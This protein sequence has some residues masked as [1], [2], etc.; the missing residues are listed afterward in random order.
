M[1]K[2]NDCNCSRRSFLRGSGLALAGYGLSSLFPGA[3]M[4]HAM[5]MTVATDRRILFI[6][7]RGGN[8]GINT[9]VP[10]GDPDYNDTNRPTLHMNTMETI[11]LGNSFAALHPALS[12]LM[13]PFNAGELAIVHRCG[14]PNNSRSHF[15]GQRIWE[16]GD[17]TQP[18]YFEGWL[19]RYIADSML[20]AGKDLPVITVQRF[21]P[22]IIRGDE[23]FVNI[24]DPDNFDYIYANQNKNDKVAAYWRQQYQDLDGL[25]AYRPL[26]SQTGVKLVD[27]IDEYASWDAANWDPLDPDPPNYSLFPGPTASNNPPQFANQQAFDFFE[28]VKICALALLESDGSPNNGTRISGTEIGGWDTHNGQGQINGQQATLLSYLGYAF[29]SLRILLSGAAIDP[30]AYGDIWDKTVVVTMSEF[31]RTTNENGSGGTDHA[32]ATVVFLEGGKVNG[33]VYNCDAGTW[34]A[35]V[36]YGA[37]GRY[38]LER[39]DYRAVFWEI[40]RDHMQANTGSIETFFPN[41][42]SLGLGAQELGLI[43]TT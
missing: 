31:G 6:F 22:L 19:A 8:D 20:S 25:E 21:P 28:K 30:R 18:Q 33:G 29:R 2:P 23:K 37:E 42:T 24:A 43:S 4:R 16:N 34:P 32:A 15:D 36:M 9:V 39:T 12:D 35:G 13:D 27:T 11:D 38:L 5:A 7:Q 17:P 14:Y 40:L 26:L 10:H 1:R 3:L 41:Y